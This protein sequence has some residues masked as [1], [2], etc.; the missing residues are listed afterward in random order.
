V[1]QIAEVREADGPNQIL[2]ENGKRRVVVLANALGSADMAKIIAQIRQE[3]AAMQ[4]PQG[5]FSSLAGT[6]WMRRG[7]A[8]GSSLNW[9]SFS[10]LM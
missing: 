3:L 6:F 10:R 1:R 5:V 7:R 9:A 2:R 8:C 4:L